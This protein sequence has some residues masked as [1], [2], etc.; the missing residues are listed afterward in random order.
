MDT[1]KAANDETYSD[2]DAFGAVGAVHR[3]QRVGRGDSDGH[4]IQ[5]E[6]FTITIGISV[7]FGCAD[8]ELA[9]KRRSIDQAIR[10]TCRTTCEELG[11]IAGMDGGL[12]A[13]TGYALTKGNPFT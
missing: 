3:S 5:C 2:T 7:T 1:S 10:E 6:D 4:S 9:I 12:S 13:T 8:G 11:S